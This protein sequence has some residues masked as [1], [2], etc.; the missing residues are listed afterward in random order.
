M[1]RGGNNGGES[2]SSPEKRVVYRYSVDS[3]DWFINQITDGSES[4]PR[5]GE[6]VRVGEQFYEVFEVIHTPDENLVNVY[7]TLADS[8]YSPDRLPGDY[9]KKTKRDGIEEELEDDPMMRD[10]WE[11]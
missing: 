4:L 1:C 5:I 7:Y 8:D 3:G 9:T 11:E 10:A 6:I 2:M